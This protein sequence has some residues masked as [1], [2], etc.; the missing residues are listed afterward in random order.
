MIPEMPHPS[1]KIVESEVRTPYLK[2]KLEEEESQ[3][4]MRGVIF[5]TTDNFSC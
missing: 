1:S 3:E 4:A 5:Q 2:R